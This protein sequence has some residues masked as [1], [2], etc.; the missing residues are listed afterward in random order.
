VGRTVDLSG[1]SLSWAQRMFAT[2]Y[3]TRALPLPPEAERR[4]YALFPFDAPGMRRHMALDRASDLP[5]LLSSQSPRH[6]YYSSAYYD[7]PGHADMRQ[8][9][10]QGADVIFDL[11]ADHLRGAEGRTYPQQ[12]ELAKEK[13]LFLLDEFLFGDF[14]LEESE[15]TLA[16]SGGRGYHAHVH[17]PSFLRLRSDERRELVD[18]IM[19]VGFDP[20][21][22]ALRHE[23]IAIGPPSPDS[24]GGEGAEGWGDGTPGPSSRGPG[25][26]LQEVMTLYPPQEPGWR[27]RFSRALERRLEIW[28]RRPLEEVTRELSE[29]GGLDPARASQLAKELFQK[30]RARHIREHHTLGSLSRRLGE[31]FLRALSRSIAVEVQG[32]TDAPVTTDIHRLIRLPGSLHGG[33]GFVVHPLRRAELDQFD[34]WSQ[35][36]AFETPTPPVRIEVLSE[37]KYPFPTPL[38]AQA[39]ERIDLEAPEALFLILR[40]EG[41]VVAPS[42]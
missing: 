20:E 39:G 33:T 32:E 22:D 37:V 41:R 17:R 15:V 42:S 10:W 18:Y 31:D 40:G 9:G 30:G 13:F 12:L 35:A 26:R 36:L 27:G 1:P 4:E 29:L 3:R 8:K 21:K 5:Q 38:Q 2:Y 14:G 7:R 16:F 11:D 24:F 34:P 25:R 6:V 28:E 19:G 23:R